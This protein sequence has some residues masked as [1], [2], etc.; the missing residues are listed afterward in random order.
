MFCR[1]CGTENIEESAF[2]RNCGKHL[3]VEKN[4]IVESPL[5]GKQENTFRKPCCPMCG[6]N[7]LQA[8]LESNTIGSGGGYKVGSGCLG[9]LLLG[10][11]GLL[12]GACGSNQ[13]IRT[14]NK[15]YW[16]CSGCG[17]KFRNE[18]DELEELNAKMTQFKALNILGIF[19]ICFGFGLVLSLGG[20]QGT[21]NIL[22]IFGILGG[23]CILLGRGASIKTKQRIEEIQS[24]INNTI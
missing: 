17:N 16:I 5:I 24:N 12:C 7:E 8:V 4:T 9:Y 19:C 21:M 23:A 6:S 1:H 13:T 2:C 18:S 22:T 15:S 10:P 14:E 3:S 11:L 20:A